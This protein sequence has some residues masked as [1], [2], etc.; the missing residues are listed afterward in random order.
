VKQSIQ[1]SSDQGLLDQF[2]SAGRSL[3]GGLRFRVD[4]GVHA[5]AVHV[6]P[7]A[8]LSIGAHADNDI[9]LIGDA[10]APH[11]MHVRV[12]DP[13]R[14][15]VRLE[16]HGQ[17]V[18]LPDGRRIEIGHFIDAPLPVRFRLGEAECSLDS[19]RKINA[20]RAYALPAVGLLAAAILLP[21]IAGLFTSSGAHFT[22]SASVTTTSAN[23]GAMPADVAVWQEKLNDHLR[24]A[25]LA[26]Q[27]SIER[28]S[29][30]NIVAIGAIDDASLA[31][32]RDALKWYDSLGA[33][34]LLINNVTRGA[35]PLNLPAIRTVWLDTN[36]QIVLQ[37][38]QS[39]GLGE[40]A[41]GGWKVEAID[42]SGV[43]FSRE[44]RTAKVPF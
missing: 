4:R 37:N 7:N 18:D 11:H 44:G 24:Q 2:Q 12:K 21:S 25:G 36:P 30:G 34:P 40:L 35:A 33:G 17:A 5:G 1:M 16:A 39:V 43:L 10:L 19:V 8:R 20:Y 3:T 29:T 22:P 27:V 14:G 15:I 41:P 38:G 42:P 13:W 23:S 31:K 6:S 28:G 26:G 32:W 9:V